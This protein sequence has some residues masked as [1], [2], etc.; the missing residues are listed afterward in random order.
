MTEGAQGGV[1]G[2]TEN[3][4]NLRLLP[5]IVEGVEVLVKEAFLLLQPL[6]GAGV[7]AGVRV[8]VPPII[9]DRNIVSLRLRPSRTSTSLFL[10]LACLTQQ[11]CYLREIQIPIALELSLMASMST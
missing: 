4:L 7:G 5:F 11:Q 2:G 3:T 8:G 1:L 9:H 6:A 10:H